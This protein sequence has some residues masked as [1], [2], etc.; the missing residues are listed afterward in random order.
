MN[1]ADVRVI[2]RL[3][4]PRPDR[5]RA[6]VDVAAVATAQPAQHASQEGA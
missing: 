3:F 4:R 5:G 1:F 2:V 6:E